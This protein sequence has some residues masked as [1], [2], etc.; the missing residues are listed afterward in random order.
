M[1]GTLPDHYITCHVDVSIP[2]IFISHI[3]ALFLPQMQIRV[4]KVI[5]LPGL[6]HVQEIFKS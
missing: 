3:N 5:H 1:C 4:V 6:C 2:Y